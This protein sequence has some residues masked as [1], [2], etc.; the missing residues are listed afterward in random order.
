[1]TRPN[2]EEL[3]ELREHI[4]PGPWKLD[5]ETDG[6]K[7]SEGTNVV[8]GDAY[9]D[10]DEAWIEWRFDAD[11]MLAAL[12]PELLDELIRRREEAGE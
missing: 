5:P 11:H 3:K 1:M 12:A 4:T 8:R 7:N 9:R 10:G 6:I 2:T